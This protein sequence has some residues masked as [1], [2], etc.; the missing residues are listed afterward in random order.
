MDEVTGYLTN[1]P[2]RDPVFTL[3]PDD[4]VLDIHDSRSAI[5][6]AET[7]SRLQ[8][9]LPFDVKVGPVMGYVWGIQ[10]QSPG[11]G[12]IPNFAFRNEDMESRGLTQ[13]VAPVYEE[14]GWRFYD[15]GW[16]VINVIARERVSESDAV[17]R[18]NLEPAACYRRG[19]EEPWEILADLLLKVQAERR[20]KAIDPAALPH[21]PLLD[22]PAAVIRRVYTSLRRP[23]RSVRVF[24]MAHKHPPPGR[25]TRQ[26]ARPSPRA[27]E[28]EEGDEDTVE[29]VGVASSGA[30]TKPRPP[31]LSAYG[32]FRSVSP[33]GDSPE[34][35]SRI[36]PPPP[37]PTGCPKTKEVCIVISDD[38][39]TDEDLPC[40]MRDEKPEKEEPVSLLC[41][42]EL[43][44][45]PEDGTGRQGSVP[46]TDPPPDAAPPSGPPSEPEP[47]PLEHPALVEGP[48]TSEDPPP[49]PPHPSH[50]EEDPPHHEHDVAP[51]AAVDTGDT[52][53]PR[54]R[55][56]SSPKDNIRS[57]ILALQ[58]LCPFVVRT[59]TV[60]GYLFA[61]VCNKQ[62]FVPKF[63]F[64]YGAMKAKKK[65]K[66]SKPLRYPAKAPKTSDGLMGIATGAAELLADLW[67]EKKYTESGALSVIYYRTSAPDGTETS[68]PLSHILTDPIIAGEEI[69]GSSLLPRRAPTYPE[70]LDKQ[71]NRLLA[72][73]RAIGYTHDGIRRPPPPQERRVVAE[74]VDPVEERW[75]KER[76]SF[77]DLDHRRS[78]GRERHASGG[79]RGRNVDVVRD[80][81]ADWAPV[82]KPAPDVGYGSSRVL[83]SETRYSSPLRYDTD[84]SRHPSSR[85]S[86][87]SGP[88]PCA[89]FPSCDLFGEFPGEDHS[90]EERVPVGQATAVTLQAIPSPPTTR[91]PYVNKRKHDSAGRAPNPKIRTILPRP[92][93]PSFAPTP[94][95]RVRANMPV[96]YGIVLNVDLNASSVPRG[97]VASHAP[98][99]KGFMVT[100]HMDCTVAQA[101]E[102]VGEIL[103]NIR[104]NAKWTFGK[105][106]PGDDGMYMIDSRFYS[107]LS[108]HEEIAYTDPNGNLAAAVYILNNPT[109]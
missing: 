61:F 31:I 96:E 81:P 6:I 30:A 88:R 5:N 15:A 59:G 23:V 18:E 41:K 90:E 35:G 48:V 104:P 10:E 39:G 53:G 13:R 87:V 2:L 28:P 40:A 107:D 7:I 60:E 95:Q 102:I 22:V 51:D 86:P 66:S 106:R 73:R 109:L 85:R 74:L 29:Y 68:L 37:S 9:R 50:S 82:H 100:L 70:F 103:Y 38:E 108:F 42:E 65:N 92:P 78:S 32:P 56:R 1:R 54:D 49:P 89:S 67:P 25:G 36:R 105:M 34:A 79:D 77:L 43:L 57:S 21:K 97:L 14:D 16:A 71:I 3:G 55:K 11:G 63:A 8:E 83:R 80:A 52:E 93:P 75:M 62:R 47:L 12:L 20:E 94:R 91:A 84:L 44:D 58:A 101:V 45:D 64:P 17:V 46:V 19:P 69:V 26:I 33:G 24:A 99:F 72:Q 76:C 4:E 27:S 98:M